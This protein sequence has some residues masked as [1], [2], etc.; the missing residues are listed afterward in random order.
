MNL[1]VSVDAALAA[2]RAE[3]PRHGSACEAGEAKPVG[4]DWKPVPFQLAR[5]WQ[6]P[7]VTREGWG[8]IVP[9]SGGSLLLPSALILGVQPIQQRCNSRLAKS[10]GETAPWLPTCYPVMYSTGMYVQHPST[11]SSISKQY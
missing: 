4:S 9:I 2:L 8:V 6:G 3:F 5:A 10:T 11:T 7:L 1:A